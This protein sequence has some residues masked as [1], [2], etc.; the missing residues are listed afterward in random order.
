MT[1][2][3]TA[4]LS[5]AAS[6]PAACEFVVEHLLDVGLTLPSLY[7]ERDGRL[8]CLAMRGYWQVFDGMPLD[9]GV[10]G[11][12]FRSGRPTEIRGV[13]DSECY[14][15]VAPAV[16]DEVCVPIVTAGR[17]VGVLNVES[18]TGLPPD[19]LAVLTQ[20][21]A[22]F[23]QRLL[24]LGGVPVQSAAQWLARHS[25][26]IAAADDEQGLWVAA[27]TAAREVTGSSSAAAVL[28]GP[29]GLR[30]CSTRP[31]RCHEPWLAATPRPAAR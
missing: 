11:A 5:G 10:L 27:C 29:D 31:A 20:T 9:A 28:P 3:L 8:R 7:L 18:T 17:V 15:A 24:E 12:T 13:G 21:A 30:K 14:L 4:A 1:S 16:V 6:V 25:A 22:V 26:L 23:A 2:S 19:A